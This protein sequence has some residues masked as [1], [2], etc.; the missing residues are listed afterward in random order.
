MFLKSIKIKNLKKL[1][2][3]SIDIAEDITV[4]KGKN[5]N[6]KSTLV[7]A[8]VAGLFLNPEKQ[9]QKETINELKSWGQDDLFK[10]DMMFEKEGIDYVLSKDFENKKQTLV[11]GESENIEEKKS[12][13][14]LNNFSFLHDQKIFRKFSIISGRDIVI[15]KKGE[16]GD[17]KKMFQ[18]LVGGSEVSPQD[19]IKKTEAKKKVLAKEINELEIEIDKQTALKKEKT[20]HLAESVKYLSELSKKETE[21][22]NL[23]KSLEEKRDELE[24]IIK[25]EKI[26]KEADVEEKNL[27]DQKKISGH[28]RE[29]LGILNRIVGEK[30]QIEKK[31]KEYD[32][33]E[34]KEDKRLEEL[35]ID[36]DEGNKINDK[37]E[38]KKEELSG[39]FGY[40]E[41]SKSEFSPVFLWS[42]IVLFAAGFMGG[43]FNKWYF[44]IFWSILGLYVA[45]C[46]STRIMFKI[47]STKELKKEISELE[48]QLDKKRKPLQDAIEKTGIQPENFVKTI[49]D[50]KDMRKSIAKLDA[51]MREQSKNMSAD[52]IEAEE[53]NLLISIKKIASDLENKKLFLGELSQKINPKNHLKIEREIATL[54]E[55]GK[56]AR[57]KIVSYK[58]ILSRNMAD[59]EEIGRLDEQIFYSQKKLSDRRKYLEALFVLAQM[60]GEA[61]V[62]SQQKIRETFK[63]NIE[64]YIAEIT[65]NKYSKIQLDEDLGLTVWSDE[66]KDWL[67][68]EDH[69]STG[70]I[71]QI[72]F[73]ARIAFLSILGEGKRTLLLLDD[74]FVSFDNERKKRTGRILSDLTLKFQIILLTC[75]DDYDEWGSV[76]LL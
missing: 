21:K 31:L 27:A 51:D 39:G 66:K 64:R 76:V 33:F 59:D 62:L 74:P 45:F 42:S 48:N 10:I 37:L 53:K 3:A 28:Y 11:I 15:D 71:D 54:N 63:Q 8:I 41:K 19:I 56:E 20:D 23:D 70:A 38:T 12:V 40:R 14:F 18:G 6:G 43:L 16:R 35:I 1:K 34:D 24:E 60:M 25:Y 30:D 9:T 69:L 13:E 7:D 2:N 32:Y 57:D 26:S 73:V 5:E 44:L 49:Q 50:I 46:Y 55:Q 75:S 67:L 65:E 4:I 22:L 17:I 58:T 36:F 47:K 61:Q 72:Y 52:K 68:P 29:K